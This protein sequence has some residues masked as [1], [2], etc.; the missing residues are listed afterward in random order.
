MLS[1]LAAMQ[2]PV[3]LMSQNRAD[4]KRNSLAEQDFV[5]NRRAEAENQ[6]LAEILGVPREEFEARVR[7]EL[8]RKL[9]HDG[10]QEA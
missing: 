6:V 8:G 9:P 2:A 1:T 7:R 10:I 3:I 4:A 5:V